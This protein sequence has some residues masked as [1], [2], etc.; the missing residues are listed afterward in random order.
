[1]PVEIAEAAIT[2]ACTNAH[3]KGKQEIEVSFHGEGEPTLN[4]PLF[5]DAT[6]FAEIQSERLGLVPTFSIVTNGMLSRRK[7]DFLRQHHFSVAV[8]IDGVG[9]SHDRQRPVKNGSS[10]FAILH[11]TLQE[12]SASG[13]AYTLQ[14]VV[15]PASLHSLV[16]LV[17]Y[18]AESTSCRFLSLEPVGQVGRAKD[19]DRPVHALAGFADAYLAAKREGERRGIS[20]AYAGCSHAGLRDRFCGA[21]GPDPNFCVSTRGL[22]SSCYGVLKQDDFRS[23]FFVYGRY[24]KSVGAFV[25]DHDRYADLVSTDLAK[26]NRCSDCYARRSCGGECLARVFSEHDRILPPDTIP[27]DTRCAVNRYITAEE[28]VWRIKSAKSPD[29]DQ[30]HS[31]AASGG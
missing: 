17:Q 15:T 24:D 2:L 26:F 13:I 16:Q 28:L 23:S 1:M 21:Y 14:A 27:S 25:F 6:L 5:V 20:V 11:Q 30:A 29:V 22:V 9:P 31:H 7:I 8:S 10:S 12:L 18:I 3:S 4:W 19:D